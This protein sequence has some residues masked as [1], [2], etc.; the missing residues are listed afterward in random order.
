MDHLPL[1]VLK[2]ASEVDWSEEKP[3]FR[4]FCR[5]MADFYA[6]KDPIDEEE[7]EE[8]EDEE[9]E[10]EEE[11]EEGP[12]K[13]SGEKTNDEN[14]GRSGEMTDLRHGE[15][16]DKSRHGQITDEIPGQVTDEIPDEVTD[17]RAKEG[18]V[19][20]LPSGPG[21][22]PWQVENVLYRAL[23]S[24]NFVPCQRLATDGSVLRVANLTDLYKVFERC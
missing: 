23:K 4:S 6:F 12:P 22:W 17:K 10:E 5:T 9:E 21:S 18:V 1:Y 2:L 13:S 7:E 15:M 16:R 24:P 11:E 20:R 14:D 8:E 3:C 19:R